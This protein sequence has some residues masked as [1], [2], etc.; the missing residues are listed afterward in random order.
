M[1]LTIRKSLNFGA[2]KKEFEKAAREQLSETYYPIIE[3]NKSKPVTGKAGYFFRWHYPDWQFVYWLYFNGVDEMPGQS[4]SIKIK[5]AYGDAQS[6]LVLLYSSI[7]ACIV[8]LLTN[9][10]S[11]SYSALPDERILVRELA[12]FS[13]PLLF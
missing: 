11:I 6:N 13:P 9:R 8:A 3:F 12:V 7:I 4:A 10:N 1:V 5:Q 2:M